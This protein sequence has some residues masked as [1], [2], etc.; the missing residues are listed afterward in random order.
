M[1]ITSSHSIPKRRAIFLDRDGTL[2]VDVGYPHREEDLL[3]IDNVCPGLRKLQSLG[4]ALFITTNQSGIARGYFSEAQMHAFNAALCELLRGGGIEIAGIYYCPFH[5]TAGRGE[6]RR[7]SPLRKPA[8]GMLLQAAAEHSLDLAASF[9]IGDKKSDVAA[10]RA[11]GCRTVL[12]HTGRAGTGE[13]E[14]SAQ[15]DFVGVDLLSAA[16]Q[17]AATWPIP[18]GVPPLGN[19]AYPPGDFNGP[20]ISTGR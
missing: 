19:N 20:A 12:V 17:I 2:N 1:A 3:L 15:A 4:F 18:T 8:P 16:A 6:Y 10:G 13:P 9:A 7:E 5:P 11:A 14:S